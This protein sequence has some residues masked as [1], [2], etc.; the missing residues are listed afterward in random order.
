MND[1]LKYLHNWGVRENIVIAVEVSHQKRLV[2]IHFH[3][4][5]LFCIWFVL[6]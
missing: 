3:H 5:R 2:Q 6:N 1:W 4:P